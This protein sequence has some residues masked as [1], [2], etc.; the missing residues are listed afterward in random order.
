MALASVPDEYVDDGWLVGQVKRIADRV[1]PWIDCGLAGLVVRSG[2]QLELQTP[3]D[4]L[5]AFAAIT[6]AVGKEPMQ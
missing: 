2:A 4:S 1:K 3:P 5:D 6:R